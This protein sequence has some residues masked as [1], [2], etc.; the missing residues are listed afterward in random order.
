METKKVPKRLEDE[1]NQTEAKIVVGLCTFNRYEQLKEAL[2]SLSRVQLP[3]KVKVEFVLVDND[4]NGGAK[5]IFDANVPD[6]PFECHYFIEKNRGLC[7]ARNRVL[8][9]AINLGATEIAMFDD[10]EIVTEEWLVELYKAI[11]NSKYH[12]VCGTVYRLLPMESSDLV[13]RFWETKKFEKERSLPMIGTNN[14]IFS[15]D[16]VKP[17]GMNIRFDN[18]FNFSGREDL[19]FSFDAQ[20]KGAKFMSAKEAIVIEKFSKNRST[21]RYLLRRWFAGGLSDVAVARR[22]KFQMT[23]RTIVEIF[24]I[25]LRLLSFIPIMLFN[26]VNG[27]QTILRVASSIGWLCGL[28]GKRANYYMKHKD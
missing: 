3:E 23:R 19:V 25:P 9:E 8:E 17:D 15:V 24:T 14:C 18:E 13:K 16:L 20:V 22:Y 6:M 10:D 28:F 12:G 21:I 4:E 1:N 2:D 7:N 5:Y 26:H 27:M 11:K